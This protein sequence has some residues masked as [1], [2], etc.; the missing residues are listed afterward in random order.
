LSRYKETYWKYK[1]GF[2]IRNF[3][4]TIDTID[5]S[6]TR[7][8]QQTRIEKISLVALL[9]KE[10]EK[11]LVTINRRL[12]KTIQIFIKIIIYI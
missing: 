1:T 4:L 5:P 6:K 9:S 12:K 8:D 2:K 3:D 11:S 10:Q 7:E